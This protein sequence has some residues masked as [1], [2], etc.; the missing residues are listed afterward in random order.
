MTLAGRVAVVTGGAQGIGAAIADALLADGLRV[1]VLD[2]NPETPALA[3]A[4][5]PDMLGVV[6]DVTDARA[7]DAAVTTAERELGRVAVLVNNAGVNAYFDAATMTEA[8]WDGVFAVD[9]KAAWL[10]ARR[11]LP[12]MQE[13]RAGAIVNVSSIHGMLTCA[14]MFP[15][16][17]AKAGID[18]L[19]RS[20]ALDLGPHGIRVNAVA[21]GWTDTAL[22]A[23]SFAREDD[24]ERARREVEAAHPL[25]RLAT[26]AE[27]AAVVAFLA[28]P[29]AAAMT[30]AV[31]RVDCGL[32]AKFGV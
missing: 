32:S 6:T 24:P 16:A 30:G 15:Y 21:P 4:K 19:T 28:G 1:A 2:R 12:G 11:V 17:A 29:G 18:G 13:R 8:E 10:C 22:V 20:M 5:G 7:I 14:G 26:P 23:E 25:G 31:V 9:L 3:A 27:V